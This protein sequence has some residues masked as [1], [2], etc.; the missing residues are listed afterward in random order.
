LTPIL[1]AITPVSSTAI[2][3]TPTATPRTW[4]SARPAWRSEIRRRSLD[5]A[6]AYVADRAR[7]LSAHAGRRLWFVNSPWTPG[8][9]LTVAATLDS[10]LRR[11]GSIPFEGGSGNDRHIADEAI[12]LAAKSTARS[13]EVEKIRVPLF[14]NREAKRIASPFFHFTKTKISRN[15]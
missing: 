14:E 7:D 2:P 5:A 6:Q 10:R 15:S 13:V 12:S 4:A 1:G 3:R 9:S 8:A 11:V